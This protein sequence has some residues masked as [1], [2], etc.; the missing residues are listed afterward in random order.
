MT[1][2]VYHGRTQSIIENFSCA[3][4]MI[5]HMSINLQPWVTLRHKGPMPLY[6]K[7]ICWPTRLLMALFT[8][9]DWVV[10][11]CKKNWVLIWLCNGLSPL[12]C[13]VII[14]TDADLS[15]IWSFEITSSIQ[16]VEIWLLPTKKCSLNDHLQN[17][18]HLD[19]G[20]QPFSADTRILC[21]NHINEMAVNASLPCI[22]RISTAVVLTYED[23]EPIMIYWIYFSYTQH[24][25]WVM[26]GG[27]NIFLG[28]MK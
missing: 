25:S 17:G 14:Q 10:Y 1:Y 21:E 19:I 26:I 3:L 18:V 4:G 13:Q 16:T 5:V 12:Q 15:S 23:K 11:M 8:S 2:N 9:L 28:F 27:V 6:G 20:H 7:Y 24:M 22:A